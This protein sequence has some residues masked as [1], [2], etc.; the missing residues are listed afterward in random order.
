MAGGVPKKLLIL[1]E[2]YAKMT[3]SMNLSTES[4]TSYIDWVYSQWGITPWTESQWQ[5]RIWTQRLLSLVSIVSSSLVLYIIWSD[6]QRKLVQLKNRL[7]AAMSVTDILFSAALFVSTAAAPRDTPGVYG[8]VGNTATCDAQGFFI[9]FGMT[10][11]WMYNAALCIMYVRMIKH[12][13]TNDH[14]IRSHMDIIVHATVIV[15]AFSYAFV[16]V[17]MGHMNSTGASCYIRPHPYGCD[18]PDSPKECTRGQHYVAFR[19]IGGCVG[20]LC[21]VIIAVSM[22]IIYSAVRKRAISMERFNFRGYIPTGVQTIIAEKRDTAIQAL[23]YVVSWFITYSI[24][25]VINLMNVAGW[26]GF[27]FILY[28][29]QALFAPLQGFWNAMVY[30]RPMY[31]KYRRDVPEDSY[32]KAMK[33]VLF[34]QGRRQLQQPVTRRNSPVVRRNSPIVRRN[35]LLQC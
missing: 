17:I 5:A 3:T 12:N 25:Y 27:P 11:T 24:S 26:R 4:P 14:L 15:I 30:I 8:A 32:L 35:S 23:L 13:V 1:Q 2:D 7:V 20:I 31:V 29:L 9:A 22:A 34:T 21:F 6:R 28:F 33:S 19:S 18:I 16:A 10:S